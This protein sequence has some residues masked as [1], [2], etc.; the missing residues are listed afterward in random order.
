M[1]PS[2]SPVW[3]VAPLAFAL[4]L[5]LLLLATQAVSTLAMRALGLRRGGRRS[6]RWLRP[7]LAIALPLA[8][9]APELDGS[10][11]M[12]PT[13][14]LRVIPGLPGP[15]EGR[16]NLLNDS[17]FQFYP[18]E[19]EVR[20]AF[21]EGRLPLWS[22]RLS[23]GSSPWSNPIAQVFSP[24][25]WA[26]RWLPPRHFF[27]AGLV[28][29]LM[30][31]FD[32]AWALAA[33]LGLRPAARLL[34]GA[35]LALGGGVFAWLLFPQSSTLAL[36]PWLACAA[37]LLVRRPSSRRFVFVALATAGTALAGHPEVALA[38]GLLVGWLAFA[39]RRRGDRMRGVATTAIAATVGLALAGLHLAPAWHEIREARRA[40]PLAAAPSETGKTPRAWIPLTLGAVLSSEAY[41]TPY[42]RAYRGPFNEAETLGGYAGTAAF[43]GLCAVAAASAVRRRAWPLVGAFAA[44]LLLATQP[45]ALESALA[46]V[47][48]L[49]R[50]ALARVLP[51]AAVV[52]A[53]A[54]AMGWQALARG[55][56]AGRLATSCAALAAIAAAGVGTAALSRR[57]SPLVL[58]TLVLLALA[59]VALLAARTPDA[60]A[61]ARRR[62][63]AAVAISAAVAFDLLTF[64]RRLTPWGH[65]EQFYPRTPAI[66]A[67]SRPEP[68]PGERIA[69]IEY[70]VYPQLLAVY[71]Y[72]DFRAHD[73]LADGRYL[74]LTAAAFDFSPD[75]R[76]YF[77]PF[78][79]A[80]HPFATF[81]GLRRVLAPTLRLIPPPAGWLVREVP[82]MPPPIEWVIWERP[83]PA[84]RLFFPTAVTV[85]PAAELPGR[86]RLLDDARSV[87]IAAEQAPPDLGE[88]H[89]GRSRRK[90]ISILEWR[91]GYYRFQIWTPQRRLLA[92]SIAEPEDWRIDAGEAGRLSPVP[93]ASAFLGFVVPA[94]RHEVTLR[95]WPRGL[96]FGLACSGFAAVV[97]AAAA[98][99]GRPGGR[100][101]PLLSR[102]RIGGA[103]R[104]RPG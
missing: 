58:A 40:A 39:F 24:V 61:R 104:R 59:I 89:S 93:I 14:T 60:A 12:A 36:V 19:I 97:L 37:V 8:V 33:A 65:A 55:R 73:P 56:R 41:G 78:R 42:T 25:A 17:L 57:L 83:E 62:G 13:P 11:P 85:V 90:G 100:L 71:G 72:E 3:P 43:A 64:A 70:L 44:I 98:L 67:L 88:L 48:L 79:R 6:G 101:A 103:G 86:I 63:L 52:L 87:L 77:S 9:L 20:R 96:S 38:G 29:K 84:P 66:E 82:G 34:A 92:T 1:D 5:G 7:L 74:D 15:T 68:E 18:L 32:G 102:R 95:Y 99:F 2:S 51:S 69:A 81:L 80:G 27:L 23:G 91:D 16:W 35:S 50:F 4:Q 28:V 75:E 30:L 94:G 21:A 22:D 46:G 47:P 54:G 10:R 49:G 53:I 26:V 45:H 31:A 76:A